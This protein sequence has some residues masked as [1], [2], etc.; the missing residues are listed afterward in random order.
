MK[1]TVSDLAKKVRDYHAESNWI[2]DGDNCDRSR[3]TDYSA[4]RPAKMD[5][6]NCS[7]CDGGNGRRTSPEKVTLRT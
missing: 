2:M 4:A 3:S 1:A 5:T 6:R 7:Y